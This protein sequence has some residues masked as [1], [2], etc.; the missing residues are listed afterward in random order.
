MN[1]QFDRKRRQR[2]AL[3]RQAR[4]AD[5]YAPWCGTS[6]AG[7]SSDGVGSYGQQPRYRGRQC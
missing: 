6:G 4:S 7:W 5:I 1:R 2:M 3:V